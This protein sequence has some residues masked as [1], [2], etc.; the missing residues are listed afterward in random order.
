MFAYKVYQTL[1]DGTNTPVAMGCEYRTFAE[2]DRAAS[3]AVRD[4]NNPSINTYEVF[5]Q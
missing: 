2:A 4:C 1:S 3:N 5:R